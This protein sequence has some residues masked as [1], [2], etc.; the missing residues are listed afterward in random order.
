MK[1]SKMLHLR[2]VALKGKGLYSGNNLYNTTLT[3]ISSIFCP[4]DSPED[5]VFVLLVAISR[6]L[7]FPI[8]FSGF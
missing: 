3:L 6:S 8:F 5:T 1:M 4:F 7:F 2:K